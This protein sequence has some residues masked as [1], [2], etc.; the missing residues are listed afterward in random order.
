MLL[1]LIVTYDKEKERLCVMATGYKF[2][3]KGAT[4]N[5]RQFMNLDEVWNQPGGLSGKIAAIHVAQDDKQ[6]NE[7]QKDS[8]LSYDVYDDELASATGNKRGSDNTLAIT[9]EQWNRMINEGDIVEGNTYE[10]LD[11]ETG[12]IESHTPT[13]LTYQSDL[14][15]THDGVEIL[16]DTIKGVDNPI[17]VERHGELTSAKINENSPAMQARLAVAR[18]NKEMF[19]SPSE[20][21]NDLEDDSLDL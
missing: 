13:Y 15:L 17:D 16:T 11:R 5:V 1:Y 3:G 12:I 8:R 4:Q 6:W 14:M 7:L 20:N 19:G 21:E 10:Y 2:E 9:E 18:R